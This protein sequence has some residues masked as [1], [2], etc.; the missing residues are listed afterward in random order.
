MHALEVGVVRS[1]A[2]VLQVL[3]GVHAFLGHVLLCEHVSELASAVVAEVDEDD[4]VA[5]LDGALHLGVVD[6]L[7]KLVGHTL[8]VALVHG[9]Q[10]V[11]GLLALALNEQVV[12]LFHAVPTVVAVHGVETSHDAGD[13]CVVLV[14]ALQHLLN[15]ALAA[16]RVAV[17]AVHE[18]VHVGL[19]QAILLRDL[20]QL[21]EVVE[22]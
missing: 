12:G 11:V 4:D 3:D 18:A 20:E 19:L 8:G 21:E 7:D 22:A 6:R 16:L 10:Q 14:A 9:L 1:H 5:L 17:A 13:V 15:E 2:V